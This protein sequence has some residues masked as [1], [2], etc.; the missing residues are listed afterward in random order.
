[1]RYWPILAVGVLF[2]S[3]GPTVTLK[4]YVGHPPI[5]PPPDDGFNT[6]FHFSQSK[7]H[8]EEENVTTIFDSPLLSFS[9]RRSFLGFKVVTTSRHVYLGSFL[10]KS[11][12]G[13]DI[14]VYGGITAV[15]LYFGPSE[16][17]NKNTPGYLPYGD[18]SLSLTRGRVKLYGGFRYGYLPNLMELQVSTDDTAYTKLKWERVNFVGTYWGF[19]GWVSEKIGISFS[20]IMGNFNSGYYTYKW[21]P[22]RSNVKL[23]ESSRNY[24]LTSFGITWRF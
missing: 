13:L 5:E 10:A 24:S 7:Q 15:Y 2:M 18:I 11:F 8:I 12:G 19:Q 3:C 23:I 21:L 17:E 6:T 20:I 22:D 16:Y 4:N 14:V 1:M 9:Y